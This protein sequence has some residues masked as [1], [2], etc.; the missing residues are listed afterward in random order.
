MYNFFQKNK[1]LYKSG[2][3]PPIPPSSF[4]NRQFHQKIKRPQ[5][6]PMNPTNN[7][8]TINQSKE[9]D[10]PQLNDSE[11]V[12]ELHEDFIGGQNLTGIYQ[13]ISANN[14]KLDKFPLAANFLL[15]LQA[16]EYGPNKKMAYNSLKQNILLE[17]FQKLFYIYKDE[18]GV[19]TLL[20]KIE[21]GQV[22]E[23][24]LKEA[25]AFI[26]Q[27]ALRK[28]IPM[29]A[30]QASEMAETLMLSV[31]NPLNQLPPS[32]SM[33]DEEIT[34]NRIKLQ[35]S[36]GATP[37][38]DSIIN[39]ILENHEAAMAFFWSIFA[40]VKLQQYLYLYGQGQDGKGSICRLIN[41][42]IGSRAYTALDVRDDH[43]P[44]KLIGKRVGVFNDI[45]NT[46]VIQSSIFKQITGGDSVL[47]TEKH[48][49]AF[50]AELDARIIITTNLRIPVSSQKSDLRRAIYP[51]VS[52]KMSHE[53]KN[54]WGRDLRI[55]W[56]SVKVILKS[57]RIQ[58]DQRS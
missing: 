6:G 31:T 23:V 41:L 8:I 17:F 33:D 22:A 43:W 54:D 55:K 7:L 52:G 16:I 26:I 39:R 29:S 36:E 12:L 44:N 24:S 13:K 14:I 19:R 51:P 25:A 18:K 49:P 21:N 53:L 1:Y 10:L 27:L 3:E 50:S 4:L 5:G 9:N 57:S 42:I 47:I 35:I 46:H 40:E 58:S 48:R 38:F 20:K 34:F 30:K 28:N 37:V 32:F 15:K 2:L 56:D 45:N 11:L